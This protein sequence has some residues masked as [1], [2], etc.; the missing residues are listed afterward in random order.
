MSKEM[1][2]DLLVVVVSKNNQ[3]MRMELSHRKA[4]LN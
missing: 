4:S 2:V 3:V 1:E